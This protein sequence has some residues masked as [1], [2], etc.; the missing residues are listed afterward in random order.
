MESPSKDIY[1]QDVPPPLARRR[2]RWFENRRPGATVSAPASEAYRN[3]VNGQGPR[4][5]PGLHP[6]HRM[7][8]RRRRSEHA[9]Q[10]SMVNR[11][12]WVGIG[13]VVV[14]YLALLGA[15]V[16]RAR[17]RPP[18]R[19]VVVPEAAP[20]AKLP[21]LPSRGTPVADDVRTWKN[22]VRLAT[23]GANASAAGKLDEAQGKLTE[24]LQLA[25]DLVRARL[26]LA[27]LLV[28][29][30]Q[31]DE[32]EALLRNVLAADPESQ[33][34]RLQLARVYAQSGRDADALTV[35]R[36]IIE[37]DN[38]SVEAH[39]LAAQSLLK[40]EQPVEAITHLRRLVGLNRDDLIA[41]NN[42]GVAYL[43]V[44]DYRAA[45]L[46]FRDVLKAD[47]GNSVAH[48][49]IAVCHARQGQA[50]EAVDVL[51]RAAL[52]FGSTFVL[53]WTQSGDFD[54]I[55]GEGVFRKFVD[56]GAQPAEKP[57]VS[58]EADADGVMPTP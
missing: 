52:K 2:R 18:P 34:A 26:E 29:R 56:E 22:A 57:P 11:M 8:R 4:P 15:S 13:T 48:Y 6:D 16:L 40:L 23:E 30:K 39:E 3:T 38:Y 37:S 46:A 31:F 44:K 36:W 47:E 24:A 51:S 17:L 33:A 55:R 20:A 28:H 53:T 49:N 19:P 1:H 54:A 45:L 35:A 14:V 9:P 21:D 27:S 43:Q 42:L 25:P 10:A 5:E 50:A 41:Q 58:A 12:L 7:R 32:A